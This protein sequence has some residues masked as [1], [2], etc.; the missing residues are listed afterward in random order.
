[1]VYPVSLIHRSPPHPELAAVIQHFTALEA[2]AAPSWRPSWAT[3]DT[4][5]FFLVVPLAN[6]RPNSV[7]IIYLMSGC[8][9]TWLLRNVFRW[10][11][12]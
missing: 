5:M 9:Q 1:M 7:P 8:G 11:W 6:W 4:T 3:H 2:V 10:V 12:R